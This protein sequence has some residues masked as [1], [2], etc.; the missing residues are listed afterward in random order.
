[1][2]LSPV[3]PGWSM[4]HGFST[5]LL[6]YN[7]GDVINVEQVIIAELQ[8]IGIKLHILDESIAAGGALET[9]PA[10]KRVA[11]FVVSGCQSPDPSW[12]T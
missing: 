4:T 11:A 6:G 8:Q 12:Y 5:V 2:T 1:V 9:G 3:S 7:S 10:I